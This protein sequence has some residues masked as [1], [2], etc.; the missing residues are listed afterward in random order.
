MISEAEASHYLRRA[1]NLVLHIRLHSCTP[2]SWCFWEKSLKVYQAV[3]HFYVQDV[4]EKGFSECK[5]CM[6]VGSLEHILYIYM[7]IGDS[8]CLQVAHLNFS[9]AIIATMSVDTTHSQNF[10][11]SAR[12]VKKVLFRV[13]SFIYTHKICNVE[14]YK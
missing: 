5:I 10:T 11:A 2:A 6:F 4:I 9:K 12:R 13:Q 7:C 14:L 8:P 3:W 1:H